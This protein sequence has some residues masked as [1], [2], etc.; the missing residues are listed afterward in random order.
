[1]DEKYP[2]WTVTHVHMY[3]YFCGVARIFMLN[4]YCSTLEY[5]KGWKDQRINAAYQEMAEHY[6]AVIIPA[7]VLTPKDRLDVGGMDNIS[8][9]NVAVLREY[10][11][12][13]ELPSL[14]G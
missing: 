5:D 8:N 11:E 4:N 3:E 10:S 14:L 6:G 7:R 9:R 13:A 2:S 1:M 12:M